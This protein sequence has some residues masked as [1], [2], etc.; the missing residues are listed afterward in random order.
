MIQF[1]IL[2]FLTQVQAPAELL[3][4]EQVYDEAMASMELEEWGDAIEKLE[5]ILAQEPSHVPTRFNLAVS[6]SESAQT[7]RAIEVYRQTLERDETLF[8]ARMNLAILFS[9]S[10]GPGT[11]LSWQLERGSSFGSDTR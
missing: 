7:E 8:E 3:P 9:R 2:A 4:L 10:T 6:L 1:L 5:A 11:R